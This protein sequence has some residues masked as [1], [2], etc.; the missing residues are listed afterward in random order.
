[1]RGF[2]E[3]SF[4]FNSDF[5]IN[6]ILR[7]RRSLKGFNHGQK[8]Q[9]RQWATSGLRLL[10]LLSLLLLLLLLLPAGLSLLLLALLL[11]WK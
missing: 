2:K 3:F 4:N 8:S 1:M 5:N 9:S 6:F 10:L 7:W 11:W